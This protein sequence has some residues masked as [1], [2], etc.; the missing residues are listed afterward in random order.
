EKQ[1][2]VFFALADHQHRPVPAQHGHDPDHFAGLPR[3]DAA[4]PLLA[5]GGEAAVLKP[6][7][8]VHGGWLRRPF[9]LRQVEDAEA[10]DAPG[11]TALNF[12]PIVRGRLISSR[13]AA[14]E[15][16][17]LPPPTEATPS[18]NRDAAWRP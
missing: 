3:R 11:Q 15:G 9:D 4:E 1:A 16:S 12:P 6:P 5:T 18:S 2:P 13:G 17:P 10:A 8:V 14:Y 7:P